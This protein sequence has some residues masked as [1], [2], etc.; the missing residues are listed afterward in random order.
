MRSNH[1]GIG[2]LVS[3]DVRKGTYVLGWTREIVEE[4][5]AS[6]DRGLD[7]RNQNDT[8]IACVPGEGGIVRD[9]VVVREAQDLV[10]GLGS[11]VYEFLRAPGDEALWSLVGVQM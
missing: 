2:A 1:K 4:H 5:V 10:A 8:P 6:L 7:A 11:E 9:P 3:P